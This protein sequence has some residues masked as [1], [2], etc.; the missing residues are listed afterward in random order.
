VVERATPDRGVVTI[1]DA[2]DL[3]GRRGAILALV[4]RWVRA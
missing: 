4:R 3:E 1:A 2:A